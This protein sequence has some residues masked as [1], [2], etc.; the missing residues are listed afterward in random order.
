MQLLHRHRLFSL[1]ILLLVSILPS[2]FMLP[3]TDRDEARFVQASKQMLETGDYTHIMNQD[4]PRLKKP[5]GIYWIQ[6]AAVKLTGSNLDQV[7]AYRLPSAFSIILAVLFFGYVSN[8]L[9]GKET[10]TIATLLLVSTVLLQIESTLGKTDAV[11]FLFSTLALGS[12]M[13]RLFDTSA[14]PYWTYAFWIS[15]G[16][17]VFIKGPVVPT[18]FLLCFVAYGVLK[19]RFIT[20][21]GTSP[22]SNN[23][24]KAL[25]LPTGIL[26]L[27]LM[28]APWI[29]VLQTASQG[30]FL[31]DSVGQDLMQ[32]LF[33]GMESHGAYP[34]FYA[35]TL[36]ISFLPGSL[37]LYQALYK[38]FKAPKTNVTLFMLCFLIPSWILLEL[39]PTKLPHYVFPLFPV[40]ALITAQYLVSFTL[41]TRLIKFLFFLRVACLILA[42]LILGGLA[43]YFG[44]PLDNPFFM[45]MTVFILLS[46][47][48]FYYFSFVKNPLEGMFLSTLLVLMI[49]KYVLASHVPNFWITEKVHHIIEQN[50]AQNL[51]IIAVG[52]PELSLVFKEGTDTK[53]V[54]FDQAAQLVKQPAHKYIV[55]VAHH[56]QKE[57][58]PNTLKKLATFDGFH[59]SKGRWRT[60][61]VYETP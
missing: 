22:S 1:L 48:V 11:M 23:F 44:A 60:Y 19:N 17:T 26:I 5:Y 50:N 43:Y 47:L 6:C 21:H 31:Q 52:Y 14:S 27:V 46:V 10:T 20:N 7:W 18:F 25:S 12:I 41:S 29:Y 53:L 59:Y 58:L 61:T 45:A 8:R 49:V 40:L 38:I 54:T 4:T 55:L 30:Q 24:I 51:P 33:K 2:I 36:L 56:E 15:L 16:M 9:F 3:L 42:P 32:K 28:S 39:V 37:F 57:A 35:L 34:G 13:L